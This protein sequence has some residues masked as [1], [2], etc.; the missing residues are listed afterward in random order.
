MKWKRLI[1]FIFIFLLVLLLGGLVVAVQVYRGTYMGEESSPD[2]RFSLR[3][4]KTFH[5]FK[6]VWSMPGDSACTPEWIRLYSKDGEKLNELY[7]TSCSRE[8]GPLW[9]ESEVFLPDGVTVW[10]LPE[11][12]GLQK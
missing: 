1:K 11:P 6:M 2:G 5:V 9:N 4:Y 10:K 8:M 7:T 3:Y 12:P